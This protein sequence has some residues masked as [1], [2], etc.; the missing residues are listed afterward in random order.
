M[1]DYVGARAASKIFFHQP[2]GDRLAE[3]EHVSHTSSIM[4]EEL[5]CDDACG[6][7]IALPLD[8]RVTSPRTELGFGRAS[9][10]VQL[11]F[12]VRGYEFVEF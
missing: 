9:H 1:G 10:S 7:L 5:R 12:G 11:S 6:N 2:Q 4:L 8:C 3:Y